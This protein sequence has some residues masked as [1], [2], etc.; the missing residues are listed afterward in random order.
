VALSRFVL[1]ASRASS[2]GETAPAKPG[3]AVPLQRRMLDQLREQLSYLHYR[4]H[5]EEAYVH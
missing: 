2:S 5:T 3:A 1:P 4:L